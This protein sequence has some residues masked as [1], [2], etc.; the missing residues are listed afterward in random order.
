MK[1]INLNRYFKKIVFIL[2]FLF[3]ARSFSIAQYFKR[4]S[5]NYTS[6]KLSLDEVNLISTY[7]NQNGDHSPILGGRGS[8]QVNEFTS[9]IELK[10]TGYTNPNYIHT[11]TGEFGFAQHT[12]ASQAWVSSSGASRKEGTRIY[13]S[14]Q[15]SL[16]NVALKT[17]YSAGISYSYEYNYHSLTLNGGFSKA[18]KNNGEF[19]A[20]FTGSFDRVVLIAAETMSKNDPIIANYA[21]SSTTPTLSKPLM[22]VT[23]ASGGGTTTTT[24]RENEEENTPTFPRTTLTTSF[25]YNQVINTRSQVALLA[26]LSGQ[27]GF[28]GLPF[29]RVFFSDI[30]NSKIENLPSQRLKLPIGIRYNY[31][32]GDN[33]I[34]RAYYRY[35]MD[36]WGIK[37]HTASLEVPYKISPLF[38]VSPF[39]RFYTQTAA[40]Y[41]APFAQ[42]LSTDQY[43]TS[44]YVYS[45]FKSHFYGVGIKWNTVDSKILKGLEL[46]YGHY[47]QTTSLTSNVISLNLKF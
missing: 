30:N 46:R 7:Y 11:L 5:T 19:Q 4:D 3:F 26:D 20:K 47:T 17:E 10:L 27:F 1:L 32:I 39:Y 12:A 45:A 8:E 14:L 22:V 25:S 34:L 33:I 35:Y 2:I 15:W 6:K 13:P 43:F 28:L 44:N 21:L 31:F 36:T 37:A 16:K 40:D 41:F 18:N 42:H 9:L 23:A 29:H 38:S 24:T